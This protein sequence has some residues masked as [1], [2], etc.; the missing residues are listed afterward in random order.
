MTGAWDRAALARVPD[1]GPGGHAGALA[2]VPL[3]LG[4]GRGRR[5]PPRGDP[6]PLRRHRRA[7]ARGPLLRRVRPADR[8]PRR[9]GARPRR[10]GPRRRSSPTG[11]WPRARPRRSTRRS[12]TSSPPPSPRSAARARWRSC[13]AGARRWSRKY[14]Y[15]GLPHYGAFAPPR[16][17]GRAR[18]VD[19]LLD[20]GTLRSTGGRF[21]KLAGGVSDARRR[22]RLGR[23][24]EPAGDPR[25]RPRPR[26]RRG[27]RGRGPTAGAPRRSSG[28]R[29][30]ASRCAPSRAA[31]TPIAPRATRRWPTWL[32][33]RGVEP[34]GARGLHA[35]AHAGLPRPLPAAGHQ[36][37]PGAAAGLPR[38]CGRSSRRWTTA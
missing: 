26:R 5:L 9:P 3:R 11:R 8:A 2:P 6:A 1:L 13:A 28:P 18:A 20:A 31:T 21:P 16:R 22:P 10:A 12:S 17:D 15:D 34:G 25:P 38:A 33:E 24:H 37:P 30:R 29:A 36:R 4:V 32:E 19:A 23:G 7:R 35:A 14:S 27:R